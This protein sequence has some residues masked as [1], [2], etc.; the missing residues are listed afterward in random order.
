MDEVSNSCV[1]FFKNFVNSFFRFYDESLI[2]K[3]DFISEFFY[4][5][6]NYFFSDFSR[7][8]F[9]YCDVDLNCFFFFNNVSW[10]VFWVYEF[11]FRCSYVYSN[12]FKCF[13]VSFI[14]YNNIDMVVVVVRRKF[15]IVDVF[16]VMNI[17]VFIDFS[18]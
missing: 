17:D 14:N 5:I 2:S 18:N 9:V 12:L 13:F 10:Y 8:V 1:F 15:V 11:R 6:N 3:R 16:N 4:M 7:F